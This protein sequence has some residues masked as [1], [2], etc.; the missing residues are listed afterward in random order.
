VVVAD[1]YKSI[2]FGS[3][4]HVHMKSFMIDKGVKVTIPKERIIMYVRDNGENISN[5][6]YCNTTWKKLKKFIKM[7]LKYKRV[8]GSIKEAFGLDS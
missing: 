5:A 6:A 4:S 1:S 7:I 3:V 8:D 2:P